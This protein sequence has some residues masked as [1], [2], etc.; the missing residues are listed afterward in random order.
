MVHYGKGTRSFVSGRSDQSLSGTCNA[1]SARAARLTD[2]RV[3]KHSFE[4]LEGTAHETFARRTRIIVNSD[5]LKS[6][7]YIRC[8]R[9]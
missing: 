5:T 7:R 9:L 3:E 6:F 4:F 8:Y 2:P 1:R